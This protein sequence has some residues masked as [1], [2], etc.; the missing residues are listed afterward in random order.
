MTEKS[1][2]SADLEIHDP[3]DEFFVNVCRHFAMTF[4]VEISSTNTSSSTAPLGGRMLSSSISVSCKSRNSTC[5]DLKKLDPL[6]FL[7][8]LADVL[9]AENRLNAKAA[10]SAL[11]AL[12]ETLLFLARSKHTDMLMSRG[13]PGTLMIVS[14]PSVSP[15]YSPPPSGRIPVFEQLLPR[16]LHYCYE[17]T[18]QAQIGGVLGFGALFTHATSNVSETEQNPDALD[19]VLLDWLSWKFRPVVPAHQGQQT[20]PTALASQR[21][22]PVRQGISSPNVGVPSS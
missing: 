10:L 3:K 8:A 22:C 13:G 6:I 21:I 7:D 15:V 20:I 19:D 14:S 5:S 9:A 16:L 4:H 2:A 18:W 12:A 1:V 11:N 17:S